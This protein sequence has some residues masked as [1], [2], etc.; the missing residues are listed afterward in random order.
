M[1]GFSDCH[2]ERSETES[3]NPLLF[4]KFGGCGSFGALRSLRTTEEWGWPVFLTVILSGVKRSRRI[5]YSLGNSGGC[6]SF[7]CAALQRAQD[8]RGNWGLILLTVI[9]SAAKNPYA[10]LG[11]GWGILEM[12]KKG[13]Y[14]GEKYVLVEGFL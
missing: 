7:G 14:N 9:L 8:D 2:S 4:G 11:V 6:G 3:K 12:E 13:W 10:L 5:R 1:A